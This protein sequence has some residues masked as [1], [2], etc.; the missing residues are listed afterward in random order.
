VLLLYS[1][2]T[3]TRVAAIGT[4]A[5]IRDYLLGMIV[6]FMRF[7]TPLLQQYFRC[8][9]SWSVVPCGL[10]RITDSFEIPRKKDTSSSYEERSV[11]YFR[12][13][14]HGFNTPHL[15]KEDLVALV[16]CFKKFIRFVL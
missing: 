16:V 3:I 10:L 8:L 4:A 13:N 15:K 14:H 5:C 11:N 9:L 7:R 1:Q 2:H 12:I 6:F